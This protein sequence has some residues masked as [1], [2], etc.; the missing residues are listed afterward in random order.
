[1]AI[2]IRILNYIIGIM[3]L[4]NRNSL[5][6]ERCKLFLEKGF[7]INDDGTIVSNTGKIVGRKTKSGYIHLS[8]QIN[9]EV[10]SL[11][12]HHLVF[13]YTHGY[14]PKQIN[15][16]V[17][18]RDKNNIENL[19]AS[20]AHHNCQNREVKGECYSWN[21]PSQSWKVQR[22]FMNKVYHICLVKDEE[23]AKRL[24]EELRELETLEQILEFKKK[25]ESNYK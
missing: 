20:D 13:Y 10:I 12:A 17:T 5:A 15:H 6:E 14:V 21:K 9:G 25:Y 23:I 16:I 7:R 1:M 8:A 3:D 2:N 18:K 11:L 24:G 4:I 22:G 19:E